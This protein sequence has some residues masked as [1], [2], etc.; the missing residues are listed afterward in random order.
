MK[1]M[2]RFY[3][4]WYTIIWPF[5]NLVHP[6]KA[7]GRENIPEGGALICANH[8]R[9]NDPFFVVFA[10]RR[11]HQIR[12]M[13]KAELLRVPIIGPLVHS[14]GVFGVERGKS[15]IG[16]IKTALKFLKSGENLL[17]FPEGTR[18]KEGE[19]GEGKGGAAML[20]VRTGVPVVPVYV[21]A[22]KKWFRR[23]PVVIGEPF[24]PQVEGRKCSSED[25]KTIADDIMARIWALEGQAV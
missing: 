18:I 6:C 5:F 9:L 15:D 24:H 14:V 10:F 4:F 25:Y 19:S 12:I 17:L 16:A 3:S 7:I 20:A 22:K 8:T 2:R 23:T 13:A 21:P 1:R 11:R